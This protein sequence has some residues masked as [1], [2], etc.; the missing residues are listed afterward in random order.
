MKQGGILI[1]SGII[2]MKE[3]AVVDAI[4]EAGLTVLS[5]RHQGEWVGVVATKE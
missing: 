3:D 1:A 5:V 2:D 4:K